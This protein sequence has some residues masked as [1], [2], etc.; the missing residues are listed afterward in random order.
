MINERIR[1]GSVQ[2]GLVRVKVQI[3]LFRLY[4]VQ[5]RTGAFLI[6]TLTRGLMYRLFTPSTR[7]TSSIYPISRTACTIRKMSSE[8]TAAGT[9]KDPVTGEMISKTFVISLFLSV[10]ID[11]DAIS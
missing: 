8:A 10:L 3:Y 6:S 7:L 1:S 11:L 5:N 2:G 9:H 4:I